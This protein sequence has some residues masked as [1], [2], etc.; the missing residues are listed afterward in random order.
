M[1]PIIR[2]P[3]EGPKLLVQILDEM[4]GGIAAEVSLVYAER[5]T[6]EAIGLLSASRPTC[7]YMLEP[8]WW[9][10]GGLERIAASGSIG[11]YT[12]TKTGRYRRAAERA[13]YIDPG[14]PPSSRTLQEVQQTKSSIDRQSVAPQESRPARVG[15]P[16]GDL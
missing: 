16:W 10:T 4:S 7:I 5:T 9:T 13:L 2:I 1:Q 15:A 3:A 8:A 12:Q 11:S 14:I 6:Q